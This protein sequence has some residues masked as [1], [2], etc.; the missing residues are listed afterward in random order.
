MVNC[1]WKKGVDKAALLAPTQATMYEEGSEILKRLERSVC[2][3]MLYC[4]SPLMLKTYSTFVD[5]ENYIIN[6]KRYPIFTDPDNASVERAIEKYPDK[7]YGWVT[8]NPRR[9]NAVETAE[10]YLSKP[11]FI[12]VKSHPFCYQ[13]SIT[14]LDEIAALCE[15][16]NKPLLIH[17]SAEPKCYKYLPEKFPNLKVIYTHAGVPFWKSLWKY[18]S[19]KPNVY[20]DLSSEYLSAYYVKK[21]VHYLG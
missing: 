20:V 13:H 4:G 8:F 14:E 6:G 7:F 12:G 19:D 16:E 9:G 3:R 21:A 2:R 11:G 10:R 1:M 17:L 18:I 5:G 15:S